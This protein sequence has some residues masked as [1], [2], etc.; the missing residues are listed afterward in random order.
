[1]R[2]SDLWYQRV[3]SA[4]TFHLSFHWSSVDT[5]NAASHED[6]PVCGGPWAGVNSCQLS[7][8]LKKR[9]WDPI[10][11]ET[12]FVDSHIVVWLRNINHLFIYWISQKKLKINQ[13]IVNNSLSRDI[14]FFSIFQID[15]MKWSSKMNLIKF[16]F[17][18][19]S[20]IILLLLP[21]D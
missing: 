5:V 1:M 16:Y 2:H 3:A 14:F 4:L 6:A 15:I 11:Q 18:V 21:V 10:T 19:R 17:D 7:C 13:K 8:L 9:L 12:W 20:V